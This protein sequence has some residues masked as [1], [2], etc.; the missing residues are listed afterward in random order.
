MSIRRTNWS[1][2]S[3]LTS[4]R[5]VE[6]EEEAQRERRRRQRLESSGSEEDK[7]S[8][9]TPN[10][11]QQSLHRLLSVEEEESPAPLPVASKNEDQGIQP[12]PRTREERQQRRQVVEGALAPVHEQLEAEKGHSSAGLGQ[13]KPQPCSPKKEVEPPPRR[14]LSRLSLE[15]RSRR[16]EEEEER[17]ASTEPGHG[18]QRVS[19]KALSPEN[20]PVSEKSSIPERTLSPEKRLALEETSKKSL[21]PERMSVREKIAVSESRATSEEKPAADK[22]SVAQKL[23]APG[24]TPGAD[25]SSVSKKAQIFEKP[26]EAQKTPATG[27]KLTLR[28]VGQPQ[29][30]E[31]AGSGGSPAASKQRGRGLPEEKPPHSAEESEQAPS[32]SPTVCSPLRPVTL[33][34]KISNQQKEDMSSPTQATHSNFIECS[35]PRTNFFPKTCT[36]DNK[37]QPDTQSASGKIPSRRDSFKDPAPSTSSRGLTRSASMK[38]EDK[39]KQYHS[40]IKRTESV[41]SPRTEVNV[42][43]SSVASKRNFFEKEI[44]GQS[45]AERVSSMKESLKLSGVVTAKVNLW[46]IRTQES[47]V[48]DRQEVRKAPASMT[49]ESFLDV[50]V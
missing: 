27:T 26:L 46:S 39:L 36:E 20:T 34:V 24:K 1:S 15:R 38:L 18:K 21:A 5:S 41:K 48:E 31:Q 6:D 12:T 32:P 10:G 7:A 19:V 17:E 47:V 23:P 45:R 33:Q 42:P 40:A 16:V 4:Q 37:E 49:A 2:L 35:S 8:R 29:A 22:P 28:R 25:R 30:P 3:R 43:L 11:D 50:E 9:P 14:R 44:S 13:A